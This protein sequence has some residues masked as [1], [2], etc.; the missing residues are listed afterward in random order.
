VSVLKEVNRCAA[1]LAAMPPAGRARR[2]GV[3][4]RWVNI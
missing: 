2:S 1:E 4:K 3:F